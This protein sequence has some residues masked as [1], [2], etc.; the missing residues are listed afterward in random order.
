MVIRFLGLRYP[1]ARALAAWIRLL[2]PSRKPEVSLLAK[3]LKMPSQCSLT[4]LASFLI[5]SIL[6]LLAFLNQWVSS[7]SASGLVLAK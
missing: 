3:W 7:A 2:I 1:R 5:R 6:L 4:V